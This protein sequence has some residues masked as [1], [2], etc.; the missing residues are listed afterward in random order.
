[1][2]RIVICG[3]ARRNRR[4][5]RHELS[6]HLLDGTELVLDDVLELTLTDTVAVE[7]DCLGGV[8]W[9]VYGWHFIASHQPQVTS[10]SRS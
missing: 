7:Q 5:N 3:A 6:I 2:A 1:M 10:P 9:C 8:P 4:S